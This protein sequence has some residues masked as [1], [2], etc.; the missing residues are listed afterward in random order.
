[1]LGLIVCSRSDEW[2]QRAVTVF[3][4]SSHTAG[5]VLPVVDCV[6]YELYFSFCTNH[7]HLNSHLSEFFFVFQVQR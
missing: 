5:V 1:M 7:M 3:A 4:G 6:D 2:L